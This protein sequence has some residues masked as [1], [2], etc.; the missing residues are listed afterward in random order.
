MITFRQHLVSLVAVFLALAVGV[1]LGGGPLSD[2]GR[3][4]PTAATTAEAGLEASFGDAFAAAAA[5]ALLRDRLADRSVVVVTLP[6]ADQE[7][8]DALR[9]RVEE[10]GGALTGAYSVLPGLLAA[11]EK[12]LVDTLG[13]Q[14]MTQYAAEEVAADAPTYERLGRLLGVAVATTDPAGDAAGPRSRSLLD[15]LAGGG[16]VQADV[17]AERRAPLVL[18]VGGA[19][20]EPAEATDTDTTDSTDTAEAAAAGD[21]ILTG[22]LAGLRQGAAGVA[23]VGTTEAGAEGRLGRVR[24]DD[25][26]VDVTTVDGAET[27]VG[28]V[29][30]VLALAR[31][32]DGT[33]G[34]FGASGADGAVPLG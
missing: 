18:V 7:V 26:L 32:L 12:A 23:L 21:A 20:P 33:A 19:D 6:G 9:A 29:T 25:A 28:Q 27:V 22:L 15:G 24:Q 10:A 13:S 14:L 2:V 3:T 1:V 4:S 34:D 11:D 17:A 16:L 8:V 31:A 30:T 5:P